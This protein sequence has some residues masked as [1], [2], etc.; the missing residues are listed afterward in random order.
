MFSH[1][2]IYL[3][4]GFAAQKFWKIAVG[5]VRSFKSNECPFGRY[6]VKEAFEKN[7]AYRAFEIIIV[8]R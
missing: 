5:G 3:F 1:L 7:T 8:Q 2:T 4:T 6:W